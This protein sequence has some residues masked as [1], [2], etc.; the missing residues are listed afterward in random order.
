LDQYEG[1]GPI[2]VEA[3]ADELEINQR[4]IDWYSMAAATPPSMSALSDDQLSDAKTLIPNEDLQALLAWEPPTLPWEEMY[5]LWL[6]RQEALGPDFPVYGTLRGA[7]LPGQALGH[8]LQEDSW[9][10]WRA[11]LYAVLGE[12]MTPD[13]FTDFYS[14]TGQLAPAGP[15]KEAWSVCG[16][17]SGKSFSHAVLACYLATRAYDLAPGERALIAIVAKDRRQAQTLHGYCEGICD[18][19]PRLKELVERTNKDQIDFTTGSRIEVHT[20][21]Y[22][23]LRSYSMA[24]FIGDEVSFWRDDNYANPAGEVL[25]AVRPSLASLDGWLLLSTSPY[26]R[27]GL[28]YE[29]AEEHWGSNSS[30]VVMRAP[31]TALNTNISRHV[32]ERDFRLD[33]ESAKAEWLGLFRGDMESYVPAHLVDQAT[34]PGVEVREYDSE[35]SYKAFLDPSGGVSDSMT[36]AIIHRESDYAVL[37]LVLEVAPPFSPRDVVAD[38]AR[39]LRSFDLY[40]VISDRVGGVWVAQLFE[41]EGII[42]R[43]EAQP[44]SSIYAELL[45]LLSSGRVR[46]LDDSTLRKQILGLERRPGSGGR[47]IIDHASGAHDDV[48]NSAAGALVLAFGQ[49]DAA[50]SWVL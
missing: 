33:P 14:L 49:V 21:S 35:N 46:L 38:F 24:A 23:S 12:S 20:C 25:R 4:V 11:Y 9:R 6:E 28:V 34:D 18:Q 31:T 10:Y 37:D 39:V 44:K 48:I 47:E 32:I 42:I 22:R 17:R 19:S 50:G 2:E 16:R 45:P 26:A 13:E 27:Q 3:T 43:A 29:T 7:L 41:E 8:V 36:V 1:P 15:C 40:E 5:D 30:T